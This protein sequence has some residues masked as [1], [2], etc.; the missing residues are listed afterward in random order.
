M[1][2]ENIGVENMGFLDN[3]KENFSKKPMLIKV[4]YVL[5]VLTFIYDIVTG[6]PFSIYFSIALLLFIIGEVAYWLVGK[7][8]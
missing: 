2:L 7:N 5:L 6:N 4:L 1:S 8:K 3:L